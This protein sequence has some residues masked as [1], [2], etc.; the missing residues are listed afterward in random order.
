MKGSRAGAGR[1][2][3][4]R[5]LS[6]AAKL[7]LVGAFGL[8]A[9]RIAVADELAAS[10]VDQLKGLSI[11]QLM[12]IEVTSV[13][14]RPERLL[15]A[16]AAVQVIT[17]EDIRRSA[18]SSI[19]SALQLASNLD[20]A[21]ENA[22]QWVISAR[23]FSSDVGNKLLVL[24]DG[25]T[26]YTPLF[27][28][29]FWDRQD[30]VLED[31]DRIEIING[32]GGTLWGANAVNGVINITTKSAKETQGLYLETGGGTDPQAFA[33]MRYGGQVNPDT[34]Y[35]VYA[36]F[37]DRDSNEFP[38]GADAHDG[39][40]SGQGGFRL[41]A[42]PSE[43]GTLTLQGDYYHNDEQ[44]PAG[45]R[46]T[47]SGENLLSRWSQVFSEKSDMSLQLY[48]DRTVLSLPVAPLIFA[49][50]GTLRDSLNTYDLD[51]QDRFQWGARNR[52]V[53]GLGYRFT[54]D[55]LVNAPALA[56]FPPVLSQ[57]L[58]SGFIQDELAI[59][60]NVVLTLGAKVE[61]NDYTGFEFEPN[62]RL[63]W[64]LTNQQTLWSAVSRAV[65]TPSRIDRDLSEPSPGYLIVIL[66]GGPQF[67]SETLLAYELGYRAQLNS[68][69]S[70]SLS[71]FY[72]QYDKVRST[73]VGPPDP[74][75]GLP[76]PFFFENNLEGD[77]YGF[78]LSGGYQPL[79]GWRLRGGYRL[80]K[81]D[82]RIAPGK[83]DFN[84]ALNET[85]DPEQ[86]FSVHSSVDFL[87]HGEV[88]TGFRWVDTRRINN[89]GVTALIPSYF[90]M[91]A[92]IGWHFSRSLELSL[93]GEN[94]LHAHHPE[95][96]V[97]GP[98]QVQI[99]RSVFAKVAWRP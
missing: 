40:N 99:E 8:C 43:S 37:S 93:Q 17:G 80:L 26:V 91:N 69:A 11:D 78:E 19:P 97:P 16:P 3:T 98:A 72:N 1:A 62:A 56:F 65:R 38:S 47:V 67:E 94:L 6:G 89:S 95:Y 71:T 22:H 75:F 86:E 68:R 20:V 70:V 46:S 54:H 61:H 63:Q 33:S 36:K 29:V 23:G 85:A 53:W 41:D 32:P 49:P 87:E 60:D 82:I 73:T 92:R 14:K 90:E 88:D 31:I 50:A 74:I 45:G 10:S 5:T 25:R 44:I 13:S 84:N 30:Y 58:F 27:S 42:H 59:R 77:T 39:W 81:E 34:S 21:E 15:Q 7:A 2:G 83:T 48:F 76:F 51:F 52:I 57:D 4:G 24:I 64:N 66:K 79:D 28:G 18:A 96:S 55:E 9:A 35:R 12:D